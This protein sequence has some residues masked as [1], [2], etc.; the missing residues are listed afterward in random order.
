MQT[1]YEL[2]AA[3]VLLLDPYGGPPVT[4]PEFEPTT[5]HIESLPAGWLGYHVACADRE[6]TCAE[7]AGHIYI[8]AGLVMRNPRYALFVLLHEYGHHV[9]HGESE[10]DAT[11]YACQY[12]R[13]NGPMIV[14]G[15]RCNT[16]GTVEDVK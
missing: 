13:G 10:L 1:I 4:L 15:T 3:L 16:D 6:W 11:R 2:A 5:M 14:T 7:D 12:V 8:D 9:L